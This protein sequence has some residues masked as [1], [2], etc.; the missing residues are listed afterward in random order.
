M[1]RIKSVA[2]NLNLILSREIAELLGVIEGRLSERADAY[3]KA[4]DQRF[5]ERASA[6]EQRIDRRADE[7]AE[8]TAANYDQRLSAAET[9]FDGRLEAIDGNFTERATSYEAALDDRI[10]ERLRTIETRTEERQSGFESRVEAQFTERSRAVDGRIDDRLAKIERHIDERFDRIE[11]RLDDRIEAHEQRTDQSLERNRVDILDR[12]DIM[13]QILEQRLDKQ[14]REAALLHEQI[15]HLKGGSGRTTKKSSAAKGSDEGDEDLPEPDTLFRQPPDQQ[16]RSFRKLARHRGSLA[17]TRIQAGESTLYQRILE[18]KKFSANGL[19][20]FS[21]DE[22]EVVDYILSFIGDPAER[23]YVMQHMRRFLATLQRIPPP[24]RSTDRLL[25]LGS[26]LHLAPAIRKFTGYNEICGADTWQADEQVVT[27]TLKQVDGNDSHSIELSNFNVE[28]DPFPYPDG[29]FRVVL[30]CELIEHLQADPMHMLW[31]CNRVLADDGFLLLTT[32]NI[33]SCRSIEGVLIGCTPYL[34]SQYNRETPID[35]HNRE[36]AP[37]EVG[38][39]LAAAGFSVVQL[40]TD[41]VW[42]RSNPA[43]M[44]LLEE[45]NL[46]TDMRGDNIFALARKTG[47]PGER[48]PKELYID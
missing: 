8:T 12:T 10:E 6:I 5:D 46:P 41:D 48:Y 40:E 19:N 47:A 27:E 14:R 42:L 31:E 29:H 2:R 16:I 11:R 15:S 21:T 9:A 23:N 34:L 24:Q 7:I 26:L 18:W 22:Q 4:L 3:E 44:T 13:L 33:T 30:C 38:I 28:R 1:S 36:Y 35:Q 37:F 17:P 39:A 45:V 43:I 32:P 20:S 25:E